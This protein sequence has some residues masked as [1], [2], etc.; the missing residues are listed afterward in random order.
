MKTGKL[1][2]YW[3]GEDDQ[4]RERDVLAVLTASCSTCR[5]SAANVQ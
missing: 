4:E 2:R 1:K 5:L 3:V